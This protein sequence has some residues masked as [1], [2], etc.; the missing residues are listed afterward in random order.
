MRLALISIF[1]FCMQLSAK[2]YSQRD[3]KLSMDVKGVRLSKALD[4]IEEATGCRFFYNSREV[5]LN[6][7]VSVNTKGSEALTDVL[8]NLLSSFHLNY[9]LLSNNVIAITAS[10]D[11]R[12]NPIQ[13]VVTDSKGNPLPGVSI[14]VKGANTGTVTN[15]Q[16]HYQIDAPADAVLVISFIGFQSQELSVNDKGT[17]NITLQDEAKGLGEVIVVGYG[18]QKKVSA[19]AAVSTLKGSEITEAPVAN[20]SNTL[21]G[22]VSGLLSF[23]GS[24][25]PGADAATI[26][27]RGIGTTGSN[28]GPLT[29]VDG[30][31]R[32]YNQIDPNE[33]ESITVLKDAAAIAPYGL[34][35]ANGVLLITTKRGKAGKIEMNLNSWL[36]Y[37]RPTEYPHYLNAY[38]YATALNAASKNA[39][40]AAVYSDDAL[41]KYKDHS[42][43]DHY[44]DHDWMREVIDF[45]APM[46]NETLTLSGGSDKVRVFSSVGRLYQQGS[47]STINYSRYN[48]ASNVDINATPTTT[49][50]LSMSATLEDTKNP[51]SQTGTGIYTSVTK[52]SPL[53]IQQSQFSNGLPGNTLLPSIYN[54][55]YNLVNKNTFFSQLSIEQKIP[56]VPGLSFKVAGA[57]DKGYSTNKNWQLPYTI[58]SLDANNKFVG[59]PSGV[60]APSLSQGFSQQINTTLQGYITYNNNF[61]KSAVNAL[62]VAES[63]SGNSNQ[64]GASRLNYQV[65]LDELSLGSS[66]KNDLDNSGSSSSSKQL[67]LVYRLGY[68]YDEKYMAEFSGR[69]DGHY[70]FAPGKRFAF[71]PAFSLGWRLSEEHFIK[72]NY[73]W[74]DN[75]KLRGSY[76]ISGNLAGAA[77]QY[78]SSYGLTSSYVFG[79]SQYTQVQGVYER[80]EANP[81]ITWETAKKSDV[82]LEGSLWRGKLNF[83]I[84]YFKER[85]SDMLVTPDAVVP[86]EYGISISQVNAGI[87]DNHGLDFSINT[88]NTFK[89][90]IT[91]NVGV[92]F[93]YAK[94]KLVQTFE[95]SA[96]YNNPN[97]RRTGR[98]MDTQ[99]GLKAI[100]LFQS[101]D[102]INSAP[103]QFGTVV[104]GDIR[105]ADLNGDKKIDANDETVIGAPAFPQIIYGVTTDI[106]WKGFDLNMLW[107]GAA[108]S[109][110][111]L[112]NEAALPFFNGAKIFKEQ[113]DSW[114]PDNRNAKYPIMLPS[115]NTNSQQVSSFWER[116]GAYLRLKT[117]QLGYTIPHSIMNRL[118]IHAIRVYGAAQNL[119]TFSALDYLDPEIGVSSGSKRARY[120]FQQKVFSFG[121]SA[122]F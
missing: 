89:N 4:K 43:P 58:Y 7:L 59:T 8:S 2:V 27:I 100:G 41:Q 28:N 65:N 122:N 54:S 25:E 56:A 6:R 21:A 57:Y 18:T 68:A 116:N 23:Q 83:E 9:R 31:P 63:R 120:Y 106:A 66:S 103:A 99:F 52:N 80:S 107:Q 69:Y 70:Y 93:S 110:F 11:V 109:S 76:G 104:P 72:D 60:T 20:I 3:I 121:L 33:I 84:D 96:T 61:G 17:L 5:P 73:K 39:G 112:T 91:L 50:A 82:G 79:G 67:G 117:A 88:A 119:L 22:R 14:K 115:P 51:G 37:Q 114:T 64:F 45:A 44:P 15:A 46:N 16:G 53:L 71:F 62:V 102:E 87:M 48:V 113:L 101:Q 26:R 81:N 86:V 108:E 74:I 95:N 97:R 77:F 12:F 42:D 34:A 30:I 36:G 47:V 55:G 32:A 49:V 78:L 75:L 105:Y 29:I 10:G 38:G 24:G 90:G 92:N 94:N 85:R 118:H 1:A 98:S 13:G 40:L 111:Q 35:G 19:T